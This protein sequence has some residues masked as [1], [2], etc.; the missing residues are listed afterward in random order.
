MDTIKYSS[1]TAALHTSGQVALW[2]VLLCQCLM[3][4][5]LGAQPSAE[6]YAAIA[7]DVGTEISERS[8]WYG[9]PVPTEAMRLIVFAADGRSFGEAQSSFDILAIL[10]DLNATYRYCSCG[11]NEPVLVQ[12]EN[13]WLTWPYPGGKKIDSEEYEREQT[14]RYAT[15]IA[16]AKKSEHTVMSTSDPAKLFQVDPHVKVVRL[17]QIEHAAKRL[18]DKRPLRIIVANFSSRTEQIDGVIPALGEMVTF[19]VLHSC[20]GRATVEV[21]RETRLRLV[22]SGLRKRIEANGTVLE[23]R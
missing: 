1:T 21:G 10:P 13:G 22:R 20:K 6:T 11:G 14:S 12:R 7:S 2:A 8:Y 4:P 5:A 15:F 19:S 16:H 18:F 9:I 23:I 17:A 3:L